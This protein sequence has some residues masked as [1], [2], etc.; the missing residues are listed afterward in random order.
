MFKK[1]RILILL[2]ILF[3]VGV[4]AWLTKIRSTDWDLPLRIVIYPIN[5]DGSGA[6]NRYIKT[7]NDESF[8]P[9]AQYMQDEAQQFELA[10][11]QPVVV[12][13]GPE[14]A[15]QPPKPPSDRNALSVMWWSLKM[16][17]WAISKDNYRGPPLDVRMFVVYYNPD[18]KERLE[19]SL[20]LEKGLIGVVNAYARADLEPRNNLVITHEFLHTVGATD[21]YDLASGMP[22]FPAGYVE[23]DK[24]PLYPQRFAEIM[25]NAVPISKTK[26]MM[27]N[28]LEDTLI[29]DKTAEEIRWIKG[30]Q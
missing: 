25:T 21:K 26:T 22:L 9:I 27:P 28:N 20:G 4:D 10:L 18:N 23:P 11:K 15:A 1:L 14:I 17:Y 29:D 8:S 5:G 3:I 2:F 6:V 16:R 24:T 30:G 7:L 13:L 12:K 19:H